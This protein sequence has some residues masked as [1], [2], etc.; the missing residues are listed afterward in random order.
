H[1]AI[2]DILSRDFWPD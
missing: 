2:D 1:Y